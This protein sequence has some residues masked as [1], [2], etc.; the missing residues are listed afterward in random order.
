MFEH[1]L[2]DNGRELAEVAAELGVSRQRI[3]QIE[4]RA[5]RKCRTWCE[6]RGLDLDLLLVDGACEREVGR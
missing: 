5:L 3:Q 6:Q 2:R 1:R 4:R